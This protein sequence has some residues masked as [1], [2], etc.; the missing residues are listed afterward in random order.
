MRPR[1]LYMGLR[2]STGG[3]PGG[4]EGIQETPWAHRVGLMSLFMIHKAYKPVYK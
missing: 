3:L 4:Q 1:D 2:G